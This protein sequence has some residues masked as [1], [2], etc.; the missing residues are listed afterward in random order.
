MKNEV[1]TDEQWEDV[2]IVSNNLDFKVLQEKLHLPNGKE[3]EH[4]ANVR[5]DTG[6]VLGVVSG[7]YNILQNS[8]LFP[9]AESLFRSKGYQFINDGA[10]V[11]N[12]GAKVRAKYRFPD[13]DLNL[14]G[15]NIQFV[16]QVQNSFDGS[17]KVSF[18]LGL[19]RLLCENGMKI[20]FAKGSAIS[21]MRKHTESLS[22]AFASDAF[23]A[24]VK[25]FHNSGEFYQNLIRQQL[26]DTE[27]HKVLNGLVTRKVIAERMA[28]KV[29]TI[30][31]APSF[32]ED[33][34]RNAFNL[35]NAVTQ[36]AS[37]EIAPKRFE[38]SER[39][40]REV[41]Q[42]FNSAMRHGISSLFVDSLPKRKEYQN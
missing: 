39:I 29:R 36:H 25:A 38:L 33:K 32:V 9:F 31:D 28:D 10:K 1:I 8:D 16:L 4:F 3:T 6:E 35:L 27:G 14:D 24:S 42:E 18:D 30:W 21:L 5:Q 37:H 34:K 41:T 22:M 7:R 12:R 26:T 20:P 23:D 13:F 19:F 2:E 11:T 40:T 15:Q 17:L